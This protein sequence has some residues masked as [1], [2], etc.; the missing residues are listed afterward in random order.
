MFKIDAKRKT[1]AEFDEMTLE[2]SFKNASNFKN[3]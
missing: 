1:I 2:G 3:G